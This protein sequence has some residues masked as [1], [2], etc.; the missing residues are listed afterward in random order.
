MP[1]FHEKHRVVSSPIPCSLTAFLQFPRPRS[2]VWVI[3]TFL[4][5][6]LL[7]RNFETFTAHSHLFFYSVHV[8]GRFESVFYRTQS[9]AGFTE[10]KKSCIIICDIRSIYRQKSSHLFLCTFLSPLLQN[11]GIVMGKWISYELQSWR[12][13][14]AR[15]VEKKREQ[16]T[17][18]SGSTRFRLP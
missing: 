7:L 6:I 1:G 12:K 13:S 11:G 17:V 3:M 14:A 15:P 18:H 4:Y 9:D 16:S 2:T 10:S 8:N 5:Q